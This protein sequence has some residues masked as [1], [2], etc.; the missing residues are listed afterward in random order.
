MMNNLEKNRRI[1]EFNNYKRLLKVDESELPALLALRP[2]EYDEINYGEKIP[3]LKTLERMSKLVKFE[4]TTFPYHKLYVFNATTE[5]AYH[6]IEREKY[7]AIHDYDVPRLRCFDI[8]KYDAA[9]DYFRPIRTEIVQCMN[10]ELA[11]HLILT[12][13]LFYPA[14]QYQFYLASNSS[15][16]AEKYTFKHDSITYK[17]FELSKADVFR[18][19]LNMN[20]DYKWFRVSSNKTEDFYFYVPMREVAINLTN[21][22]RKYF[23]LNYFNVKVDI[24][25]NDEANRIYAAFKDSYLDRCIFTH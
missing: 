19:G 6:F 18:R 16:N 13:S 2:F 21:Y 5:E 17:F 1:Q 23:L 22:V 25:R 12:M 14:D 20:P 9:N 24:V 3:N 7:D 8:I 10:D 11:E 15:F 4:E